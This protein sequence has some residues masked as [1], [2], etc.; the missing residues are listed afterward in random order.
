M[1]YA[2][3]VALDNMKRLDP[4]WDSYGAEPICNACIEKAKRM[5]DILQG[6]W[7]AVPCNDGSVQLEQHTD[8]FDIEIVIS[9]A[10]ETTAP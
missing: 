3:R 10:L 7:T 4:N 1:R 9:A 2:A 6:D 8:G 5:L